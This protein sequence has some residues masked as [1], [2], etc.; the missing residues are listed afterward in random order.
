MVN[1]FTRLR[2]YTVISSDD[3]N[4]NI[5]RLG[6]TRTHRGKCFVTRS[7]EESDHAAL[8]LNMVSTNVLSNATR[9]T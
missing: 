9:F 3:Q 4:H 8:R 2:H 6:A 5:G 1:C 7:I